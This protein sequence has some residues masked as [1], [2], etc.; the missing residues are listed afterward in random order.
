MIG[1]I[2]HYI[3]KRRTDK[4]IQVAI[5]GTSDDYKTMLLVREGMRSQVPCPIAIQVNED[6]EFVYGV[7]IY[8]KN[9]KVFT[10]LHGL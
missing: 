8:P 6:V 2:K 9:K 4:L 3:E 10:R 7:F 5:V 1:F